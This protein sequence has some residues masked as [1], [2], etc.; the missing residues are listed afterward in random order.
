[1][2]LKMKGENNKA[3]IAKDKELV[4]AAIALI[5]E[6]KRA[7]TSSIQRKLKIGYAQAARILDKLEADGIVGP[8]NGAEP[9]QI[10]IDT[11]ETPEDEKK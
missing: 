11:E 4:V 2:H 5:K 10:L 6:T 3:E 9:R 8:P 7:T 1:M